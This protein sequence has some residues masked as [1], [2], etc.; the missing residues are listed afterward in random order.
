MNFSIFVILFSLYLINNLNSLKVIVEKARD[1][2]INKNVAKDEILKGS[3]VVSGEKEDS[4]HVTVT[5]PNSLLFFENK[6]ENYLKPY[7][8]FEILVEA[9]GKYILCFSCKHHLS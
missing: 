7:G 4:V 2:C 5:G 3:F 1:F 8:E 9:S 6:F